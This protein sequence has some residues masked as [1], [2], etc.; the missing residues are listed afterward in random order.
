MGG[1]FPTVKLT[2]LLGCALTVTTT[3]PVVAPVG[4]GAVMLVAPHAVGVAAVPLNVTVLLPW[5]APKFA[6]AMETEVPTGPVAGL[7]LVMDG[8]GVLPP[9]ARKATI[10]MIHDWTLSR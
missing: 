8:A 6:P 9:A 4:T 3:L 2:P 1:T 7:R 5:E 10:C